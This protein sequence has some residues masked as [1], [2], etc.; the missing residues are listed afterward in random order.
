MRSIKNAS[1]ARFYT[2]RGKKC[3]HFTI[4]F[5]KD[6]VWKDRISNCLDC[7][8]QLL[9][10]GGFFPFFFWSMEENCRNFIQDHFLA[11]DITVVRQKAP[12]SKTNRTAEVY[13]AGRQDKIFF[14][15]FFYISQSFYY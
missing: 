8:L 14:L 4:P 5:S 6:V 2:R 10:V 12:T 9:C 1:A 7:K 15:Y 3:Q 11:V 13:V